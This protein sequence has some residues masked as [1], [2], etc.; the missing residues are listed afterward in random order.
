M[1]GDAVLTYHD[2]QATTELHFPFCRRPGAGVASGPQAWAPPSPVLTP[3]NGRRAH[4]GAGAT[5]A[6]VA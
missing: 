3:R 5:L 6:V 2:T 1:H 4:T